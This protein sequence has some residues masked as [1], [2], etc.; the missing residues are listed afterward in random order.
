MV[1]GK[2][3]RGGDH[4][5]VDNARTSFGVF[6]DRKFMT[7]SPLLRDVERRIAEWTHLPVENGESFYCIKYIDGQEYKPH[8]DWFGDDELGRKHTEGPG[9]RMATVLTYLESPEEG[10]ETTFPSVGLT[11]KAKA[12]DSVLFWDYTPD[13]NPDSL[14]LHG[15]NPVLKG[16]KWSMPK[17]IR[18]RAAYPY[19]WDHGMSDE[20][21][22]SLALED[23]A[24]RASH[25]RVEKQL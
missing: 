1:V 7:Q 6:F 5:K 22:A 25:S 19:R 14:T 23:E 11:V 20:E 24:W 10:G 12:G 4:G 16:T 15:A 21:K 13:G 3:D 9:N 18:Q 8:M 17:W 2:D